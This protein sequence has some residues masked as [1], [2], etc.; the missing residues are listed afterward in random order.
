MTPVTRLARQRVKAPTLWRRVVDD[1]RQRRVPGRQRLL[2][3][4]W[5]LRARGRAVLSAQAQRPPEIH[6]FVLWSN[7]LDVSAAILEDVARHFAIRD[8]FRVHWPEDT[9]STNLTRF[10]GGLL[11][12][13]AEKEKHCGTGP[14]LVAVVEDREP[15]YA[16]RPVPKGIVNA[17]M[18]EAKQRYREWTGG[19]HR[20]HATLDASEAEHDLQLLLGRG[21]DFY[22][23]RAAAWDGAETPWFAELV[24]AGG[25][26]D[27]S[28]LVAAISVATPCIEIDDRAS[29]GRE[30]LTLQVG[31][32]VRA[33]LTANARPLDASDPSRHEVT[34]GGA[35]LVLE[36]RTGSRARRRRPI[37]KHPARVGS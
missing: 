2:R 25:W 13:G 35:P 37:E 7:A 29:T 11:P 27:R 9:F 30:S 17:R 4:G 31:D 23:E 21:A 34:V 26:R 16:P 1:L 15:V 20:I 5:L 3:A 36:L 24:G 6:V 19:G 8:V 28:E 10:Y 33:A 18:F 32:R 22:R 12:P 14:F